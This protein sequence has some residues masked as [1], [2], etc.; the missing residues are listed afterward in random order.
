GSHTDSNGV[1]TN[2]GLNDGNY[3]LNTTVADIGS[4]ANPAVLL[5]GAHNGVAGSVTSGTSEV[6]EFWRLYGDANGDR[7]VDGQDV[8]ALQAAHNMS[9]P[10][11]GADWFMDYDLDNVI[12]GTDAGQFNNRFFTHLSP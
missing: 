3:F 11:A 8:P 12:N 6:D 2:H 1:V 9:N 7:S 4:S 5:D 10:D